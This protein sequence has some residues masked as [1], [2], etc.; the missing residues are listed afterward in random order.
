M[1]MRGMG[2]EMGSADNG[3]QQGQGQQPQQQPR[4]RRGFGLGDLLQGAIP[5]P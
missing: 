2:E 5:H 4:K 3:Q 1:L